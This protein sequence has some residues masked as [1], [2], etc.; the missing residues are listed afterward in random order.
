MGSKEITEKWKDILTNIDNDYTHHN[1]YKL[2]ESVKEHID[3]HP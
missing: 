3:L 1:I 2:L